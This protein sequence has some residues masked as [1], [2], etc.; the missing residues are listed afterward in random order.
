MKN[1]IT[2]IVLSITINNYSQTT[3][4]EPT[5]DDLIGTWEWQN[6]TEIFRI[7]FFN[8]SYEFEGQPRSKLASHFTMVEIDAIG[9]ETIIYTSDKPMG[10][11]IPQ[12]WPPVITGG[13]Y[14]D[15]IDSYRFWLKDNTASTYLLGNLDLKFIDVPFRN[16][17]K[18][19]WKLR[20]DGMSNANESFNVP[21]D[22]ILIKVD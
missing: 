20:V 16:P 12:N 21:T 5:R 1:I 18:V 4:I 3:S 8:Y 22:I 14:L 6:G 19:T 13:Q 11:T 9:N 10:T 15:Y 2:L 17:L 7:N